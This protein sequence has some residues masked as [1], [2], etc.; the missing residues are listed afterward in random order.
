MER[1][2]HLLPEFGL[3]GGAAYLWLGDIEHGMRLA[4]TAIIFGLAVWRAY[5]VLW[6]GDTP[7]DD[8]GGVR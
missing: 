4:T 6:R 7:H 8:F 1:L 5:R 2:R 3:S